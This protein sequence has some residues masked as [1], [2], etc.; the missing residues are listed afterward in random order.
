MKKHNLVN[1]ASPLISIIIPTLNRRNIVHHALNSALAQNNQELIETIVL[2]NASTDGTWDYLLSRIV[3]PNLRIIRNPKSL[4]ICD[5]WQS[6]LSASKGQYVLLLGDDDYLLP[7][8]IDS[9]IEVI[10]CYDSPGYIGWNHI[11]YIAANPLSGWSNLLSTSQSYTNQSIP[12]TGASLRESYL[13]TGKDGMLPVTPHPSL[14]LFE[15]NQIN[16]VEKKFNTTWF[17]G[18]F[19]D[20]H[21]G[22]LAG[23]FDKAG[24]FI[25]RPL[26][27]IGG[28][29]GRYYCRCQ[30]KMERFLGDSSI[31]AMPEIDDSFGSWSPYLAPNIARQLVYSCQ[32]IGFDLDVD[33]LLTK[34]LPEIVENILFCESVFGKGSHIVDLIN[35][36]DHFGSEVILPLI[37]DARSKLLRNRI[38][39]FVNK[40]LGQGINSRARW[41]LK[42][43]IRFITHKSISNIQSA[44]HYFV[45]HFPASA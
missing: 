3:A 36:E 19:P 6:A 26:V 25:D 28:V 43:N 4:N 2:D 20:Y 10:K 18:L 14:F 9:I 1:G 29:E 11:T 17:D 12:I 30:S 38:N 22:V 27:C 16:R 24:V 40:T 45:K 39:S 7:G 21:A 31:T 8:W 15:R 32:K 37:K 41:F 13:R 34:L 5:N 23:E 35:M 33:L 42:K 44:V